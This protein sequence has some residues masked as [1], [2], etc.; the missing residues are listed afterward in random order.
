[1]GELG[2]WEQEA[3]GDGKGCEGARALSWDGVVAGCS[4]FEVL[5]LLLGL[6]SPLASTFPVFPWGQEAACAHPRVVLGSPL[7]CWG[8]FS[9]QV[10]LYCP[11]LQERLLPIFPPAQLGPSSWETRSGHTPPPYD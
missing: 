6:P 10:T 1:M 9:S 3:G 7:L 2:R 5:S 4:Q 8:D 11:Y